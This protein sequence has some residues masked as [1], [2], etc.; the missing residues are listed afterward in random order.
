MEA[1]DP[2][3]LLMNEHRRIER[4]LDAVRG[5]AAGLRADGAAPPRADL[6][7]LVEFIREYADALHHG[8]EEAI[9]FAAMCRHGFSADG[10]PIAVMLAEHDEGR[11]HVAAMAEIAGATGDWTAEERA[12]AARALEG[13]A[14]LLAPHIMKED[15]ILYPMA[16]H[17]LPEEAYAEVE[18]ACAR[19]ES[20][21]LE[22]GSIERLRAL[23]DRL[24]S[25]Y[26]GL[27]A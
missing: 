20:S 5:Y 12:R 23:G 14:A 2:I 24:V 1:M 18:R 10:G 4:V 6:A 17:H 8:K 3:T 7:G 15:Q 26:A 13:Y 22:D 19:F 21:R 16:R 9:L 11:R 25:A 27:G